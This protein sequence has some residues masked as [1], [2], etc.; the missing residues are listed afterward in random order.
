MKRV[1]LISYNFQPEPLVGTV[2]PG[3][4]ARY[5]PAFGWE[6]TVLT[7]CSEAPPFPVRVVHAGSPAIAPV[8]GSSLHRIPRRSRLRSMLRRIKDVF[9]FPD[10]HALWIPAAVINGV[11]VLRENRHDAILT[12]ALPASAHVVGAALSVLT[13]TPWI[14]DYRDLWSR[15]PNFRRGNLARIMHER[16]E[17]MLI[18]RAAHVTTISE[19]LAFDLRR[20]HDRDVTAI[21]NAFDPSEWES[22]SLEDPEFFDLVYT[23]TMYGGLRSA[24]LL[25]AALRALRDQAH[26]LAEAVRVH[27]YGRHNESVIAEARQFGMDDRVFLHGVVP[28]PEAMRAQRRAAGLLIFLNTDPSTLTE[29]GSKYLEYAGARRAILVFGPEQSAL[30]EVVERGRLGQ[31]ASDIAGA[32]NALVSLYERYTQGRFEWAA[33]TTA[34]STAEELARSF[35]RCL[36]RATTHPNVCDAHPALSGDI[37]GGEEPYARSESQSGA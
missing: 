32:T 21:E 18:K 37:S 4:I 19:A 13:G 23:G 20:L 5:L 31:F 22:I 10:D 12:T 3:Y 29:R 35:A 27:F 2:R 9:M 8:S 14:A 1:L 16:V 26:P 11:R 24:S 7:H 6:A 25:F 17:R 34:L 15:N 33:D 30:R 28:R 36:D